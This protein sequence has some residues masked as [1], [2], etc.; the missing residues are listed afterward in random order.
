[1]RMNFCNISLNFSQYLCKNSCLYRL[2]QSKKRQVKPCTAIHGQSHRTFCRFFK[3]Y[4]LFMSCCEYPYILHL[5]AIYIPSSANTEGMSYTVLPF[6]SHRT[7]SPGVSDVIISH[8]VTRSSFL[9]MPQ[10]SKNPS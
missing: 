10:F 8:A 4:M 9:F 2:P 1:M 6:F 3:H 7:H 5:R